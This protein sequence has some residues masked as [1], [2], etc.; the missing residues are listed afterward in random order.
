MMMARGSRFA[1]VDTR[2]RSR[3]RASAIGLGPGSAA[4]GGEGH[5]SWSRASAIGLRRGSVADGGEGADV[6]FPSIPI[7]PIK[8]GKFAT[9]CDDVEEDCNVITHVLAGDWNIQERKVRTSGTTGT[10]IYGLSLIM[11]SHPSV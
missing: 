8:G 9:R 11:H 4:D 5:R 10:A 7:T 3:S 2:R 6:A 1:A